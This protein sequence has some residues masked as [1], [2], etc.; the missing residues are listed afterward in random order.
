MQIMVTGN[1]TTV[2]PALRRRIETKLQKLARHYDNITN[3]HVVVSSNK[4]ERNAEA[5]VHL[6][7]NEIFA[8]ASARDAFTAVDMLSDKLDR[9]VIKH[10]EK[11]TNHRPN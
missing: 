7:G 10:K 2:T 3:I 4:L 11:V 8:N 5:T 6:G 1:H 9:Q